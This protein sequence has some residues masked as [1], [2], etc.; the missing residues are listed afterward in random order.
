[1]YICFI[2]SQTTTSNFQLGSNNSNNTNRTSN[3]AYLPVTWSRLNTTSS[4]C[5]NYDVYIGTI[6]RDFLTKWEFCTVGD[7]HLYVNQSEQTQIPKELDHGQHI[8]M[9][10]TLTMLKVIQQ[11]TTKMYTRGKLLSLTSEK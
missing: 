3:C 11:Y 2:T 8:F 1:M 10:V 5:F 4:D 6:C 9:L 7:G